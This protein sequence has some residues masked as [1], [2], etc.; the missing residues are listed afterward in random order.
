V[1]TGDTVHV[2]FSDMNGTLQA[3]AVTVTMKAAGK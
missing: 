1:H 2:E 3:N